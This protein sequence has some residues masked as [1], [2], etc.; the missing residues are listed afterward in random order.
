MKTKH[1]V[2]GLISCITLLSSCVGEDVVFVEELNSSVN[3][4]RR[5][6][7]VAED[8]TTPLNIVFTD[9]NNEAITDLS[10]INIEFSSDDTSIL[11]I[12]NQGFIT[13]VSNGETSIRV[14]ASTEDFVY[15]E[16]VDD[17]IVGKV[18]IAE[19][20]AQLLTEEEVVKI[21]NEGYDPKITI[22]NP[23]SEIDIEETVQLTAIYQNIKNQIEDV[24]FVWESSDTDVLEVTETGLII[25]ITRGDA[26][27]TVSFDFDGN[28]VSSEPLPVTVSE[29]TVVITPDPEDPDPIDDKEVIGF[30][31]LQSN[32]SYIVEGSFVIT[33]E[34]GV[35]TL[36][37]ESDYSSG[38]EDL[39]DLVVYLSNQTNTNNGATFISEDVSYE[40]EHSFVIPPSINPDDYQN[41][42][43]F[44]RRFGARVGFGIIN[45]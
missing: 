16:I 25:P 41:V 39:P 42:L 44:C 45:R 37:L 31:T 21:I 22:T 34:N 23:I 19:S 43:L 7:S 13:P 11:T 24:S 15:P 17:I 33:T 20:E 10:N 6:L 27:I 3:F 36:T 18:T 29:E 35:T 38:D 14:N 4:D 32:S 28:T 8:E 40:G 5:L 12:D 2:L 9:N 30:G 1:I 26:I